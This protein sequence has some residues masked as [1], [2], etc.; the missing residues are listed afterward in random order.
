VVVAT[1]LELAAVMVVAGEVV[2]EEEVVGGEGKA[3]AWTDARALG[4]RTPK[5][6]TAAR[7]SR[8][9]LARVEARPSHAAPMRKKRGAY[10]TGG[11]E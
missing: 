7:S 3:G 1:V 11:S 6:G 2:E 5:D 9:K 4:R 10:G 8:E